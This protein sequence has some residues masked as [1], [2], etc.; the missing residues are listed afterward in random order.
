MIGDCM[1]NR[2][3]EL[4]EAIS[5]NDRYNGCVFWGRGIYFVIGNGKLWEI[6]DDASCS[7]KGGWFP[8]I[9]AGPT[10]EEDKCLTSKKNIVEIVHT[11]ITSQV[12]ALSNGCNFT[13]LFI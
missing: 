6:S 11:K 5:N 13:F 9:V 2:I 12:K 7:P 1:E 10:D 8:D 4:L 3:N